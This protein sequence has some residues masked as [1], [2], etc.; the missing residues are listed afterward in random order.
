MTRRG[1]VSAAAAAALMGMAACGQDT[2][3]AT[4]QD[5]A[6][7]VEEPPAEEEKID[8]AEF[9]HLRIDMGAWRHDAEH[10]VY[11]Q[12]GIPY[13]LHPGSATYETL[14]LFVPGA[15]LMLEENAATVDDETQSDAQADE[16][17]P[18]DPKQTFA[19]TVNP[20]ARV[21]AYTPSTAPV[22]MPINSGIL[23]AQAS[24]ASYSY[25]GL[26]PYLSAGY[27]YVYAGFRGRNSGYETRE[28]GGGT[29][30]SGG[31]PWP[32]VDLK[33]A[34]RF[35][36]YNAQVLPGNTK[37]VFV[38]GFS[39]GG[40]LSAVMGA[41]GDAE[42][43]L[44]YLDE[45]GAA[46]HDEEGT[47]L[48]DA[49]YGSASWCPIT[50]FDTA[51]A[52]YEWMMGQYSYEKTRAEGTWTKLLSTDLARAFATYINDMDLRDAEDA[53]LT[54]DDTGTEVFAAGPYYDYLLGCIQ[55]AAAEFFAHTEFPYTSAPEH[56]VN[57][58]FPGDPNLQSIGAGVPDIEELMGD[59]SAEAARQEGA[60][61]VVDDTAQPAGI[62]YQTDTDYLN[63]LNSD[64]WWLTYNQRRGTVF[65]QSLGDFVCHV[66]R[67]TKPVCAFDAVNRSTVENQ[68]FG[69]DDAGSLHFS[70]MVCNTL[71]DGREAYASGEGW[72]DVLV[73]DWTGDL[74]EIDAL[75]NS[76]DTRCDLFNP[77]YYVSGHYEGYGAAQVAPHWRINSGLF[78]TDTSLCTEANLALALEHYDGVASVAFT[79]VW[80][81]GHVLAEVSGTA[82][83]NLLAWVHACCKEA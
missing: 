10:D 33:A 72:D 36:R 14:A 11:Y 58:S 18:L 21:G 39:A 31:A 16:E 74:T 82:E 55:D 8:L 79:P 50:S 80:G 40:G 28:M 83:E 67:A 68:L 26:E 29:M 1:F 57:A 48:S 23:G 61:T 44:P 53:P 13:C 46:T 32:A 81:Q 65:V 38:Y 43:Y 76:I 51:D 17:T 66:K 27:I 5:Q 22:L 25:E 73:Q 71:V 42:A 30:L 6:R 70:R 60:E 54:L 35:L 9:K 75:E 56:L 52:A 2:P 15:Y 62:T 37:R 63:K 4:E 7:Q 69:V 12:L 45:I 49:V 78:Q 77:L 20:K 34:I 64:V 47:S 41:S 19:C 3:P 59:A 24:P